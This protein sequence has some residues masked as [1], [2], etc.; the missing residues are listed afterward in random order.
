[1]FSSYKLIAVKK[2]FDHFGEIAIEQRVPRTATVITK[3]DCIFATLSYD[4]YQKVLGWLNE[5]RRE[6]KL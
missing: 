2:K 1:M 5:K 6:E 3:S 4:S